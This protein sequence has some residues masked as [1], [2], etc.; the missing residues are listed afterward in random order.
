[1]ADR[2]ATLDYLSWL[3]AVDAHA[4]AADVTANGWKGEALDDLLAGYKEWWRSLVG[5]AVDAG[6]VFWRSA[7]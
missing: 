1:M 7:A 3:V 6:L 2:L 5:D 4:A